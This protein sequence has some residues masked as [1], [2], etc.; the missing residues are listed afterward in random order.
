MEQEAEVASQVPEFPVQDA[1]EPSLEESPKPVTPQE[2]E[3]LTMKALLEAGVHFGH[4]TRRWHPGMK[5]Y[6]FAVRNGIH[7]IDLSQ[8]LGLLER[9][10]SFIS[11]TVA[12]GE[13]VL[14]LGTKK[15]AQDT[16][17][18]EA[19]RADAFYVHQRWLGG[20]FTNFTTIQTRI[21]YLVQLEERRLKGQF[22]LLPRERR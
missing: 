4:Q 8:T 1:S 17:V 10:C 14:F 5:Q 21:D 12:E 3:P 16:I 18:R 13:S 7:I 20:T 19:S 15:Q 22:Q 11:E 6:I 9:A 2:P